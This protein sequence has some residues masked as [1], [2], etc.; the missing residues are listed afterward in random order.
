MKKNFLIQL[1]IL[2]IVLVV[3][4]CTSQT[5]NDGPPDIVYGEDICDECNMIISEPRFSAAYYTVSNE[6]RRFDDIGNM[7]L[8]HVKNMEE[9]TTFW[10]HDFNTEAWIDAAEAY[11]VVDSDVVTPMAH[12][13]VAFSSK[14]AADTHVNE[15]GGSLKQFSDVQAIY[16]GR[17]ENMNMGGQQ[18]EH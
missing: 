12:G 17:I 7:F 10:V 18:H 9:V 2:A 4:G 8:Y 3:V 13:I 15:H 6:A 1:F 5:Q 11:Y 16:A 14:D